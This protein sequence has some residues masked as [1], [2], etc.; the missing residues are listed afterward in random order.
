MHAMLGSMSQELERVL[1]NT[2]REDAQAQYAFF[3]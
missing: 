1:L 2:Y 3:H